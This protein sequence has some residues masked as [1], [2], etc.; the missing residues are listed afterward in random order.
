V[1]VKPALEKTC[2][3]CE[4][5]CNDREH[6]AIFEGTNGRRAF[7]T[8][9]RDRRARHVCQAFV[10]ARTG[11][12]RPAGDAPQGPRH[13]ADMELGRTGRDH[14]GL[15]R[16]LAADG[17][18]ARRDHRRH[19][20]EPR[21][22]WIGAVP[23]PVYADSVAE[24]MAYVLDHAEAVF[25]CVQDQEQVDKVISIAERL[26]KLC[27]RCS[28]TSRAAC[29]TTTTA[30]CTRSSEV[31]AGA[32]GAEGEPRGRSRHRARDGAG[33]G[34]DLGIILYT[35]GTTGRPKG[36]MLSHFNVITAAEIGHQFDKLNESD[37]VIAYLPIAWVGD[38]SSPMRR[39]S[40]RASAS[41]CPGKAGD[42]ETTA[43]GRARPTP[44]RRHAS[45]RRC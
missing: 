13:L 39:R 22:Y 14:P 30:N 8:S 1:S 2:Q 7:G 40:S 43:R 42:G 5:R 26:P 19:R 29:A 10:R 35:S 15:R 41:N 9:K 34:S 28:M 36:V 44:S 32:R 23:V 17:A 21:M 33:S 31:I 38:H 3:G 20:R 25:A 6:P 12:A 45:S 4:L 24:E 11:A 18:G 27:A 16:R 37:E